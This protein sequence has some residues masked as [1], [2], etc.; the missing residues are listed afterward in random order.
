MNHD[1]MQHTLKSQLHFVGRGLH[2][3]KAVRMTLAP[4]EAFTGYVFER[5]DL[6]PP[7]NT[8][9]AR[10]STVSDTRLSTT[11]SNR[12]GTSVS[13]IEHLIAALHASGVDNCRILLDG[14]EV[15]VMDGSAKVF[16]DQINSVGLQPLKAERMAIVVT[17][18]IWVEEDQAKVGLLPFPAPWVDM[19]IDFESEAIGEQSVC[20]PVTAEHFHES[21]CG[22]RTFGFMEQA[23]ALRSLG[24]AQGGSLQN[25]V[26][27]EDNRVLNREGLRYEDE[28]VR[29]KAVDAIGDLALLG[30]HIVGCFVGR[31]SGHR[32]NNQLLRRLMVESDSW[33]YT[34]LQDATEYWDEIMRD[35]QRPAKT[36]N[37]R[38]SLA[39]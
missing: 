7:H 33:Y 23:T 13:T 4:A 8:V 31:R 17:E 1:Y 20:M 29:H 39:E 27:V 18:S 11:V 14:P 22:A 30:V 19:S 10:W 38:T 3:G 2:S 24:L 21:V 36:T 12:V 26:V 6:A 32:L 35:P 15:P 34:T 28:F 9:L 25:T 16:V 5:A 37:T